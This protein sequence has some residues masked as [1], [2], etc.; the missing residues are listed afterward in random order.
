MIL[1]VFRPCTR[2]NIYYGESNLSLLN[3]HDRL[4]SDISGYYGS[5]E[6]QCTPFELIIWDQW[7]FEWILS[8][9]PAL[10]DHISFQFT[11]YTSIYG[12]TD[13][14][15]NTQ[16]LL[17]LFFDSIQMMHIF[18]VFCLVI[19]M[20]PTFPLTSNMFCPIQ[21]LFAIDLFIFLFYLIRD[22]IHFN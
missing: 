14:D 7:I 12:P 13:Q 15:F 18:L 16:M 19:R 1:S 2:N 17:S 21:V 6:L 4:N 8:L 20:Y 10:L 3:E 11:K 5:W 9:S 22:C